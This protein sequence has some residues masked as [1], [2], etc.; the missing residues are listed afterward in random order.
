MY[1]KCSK[2]NTFPGH[3]YLIMN[4]K[5]TIRKYM[6][7]NFRGESCQNMKNCKWCWGLQGPWWVQG[8]VLVKGPRKRL[9]LS[10]FGRPMIHF[11]T[12]QMH[13]VHCKS[14]FE[15]L[16]L[17]FFVIN[18]SP[19]VSLSQKIS[20]H[21]KKIMEEDCDTFSICTYR[22]RGITLEAMSG[23]KILYICMMNIYSSYRSNVAS[24]I[25]MTWK[26]W[27]RFET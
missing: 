1:P 6:P 22:K 4:F 3:F 17:S 25:G 18:I 13:V 23:L 20:Q 19:I 9:H 11:Q 2:C 24:F 10:C 26:L 14:L 7:Y 12:A 5:V 16:N 15:K 27:K 21:I 8:K